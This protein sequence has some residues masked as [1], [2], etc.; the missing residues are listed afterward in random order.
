VASTL[1]FVSTTDS[2]HPGR[3]KVDGNVAKAVVF[4]D[5]CYLGR[6]N[7]VYDAPREILKAIPG[8]TLKETVKSRNK[9][10]C[11]GA[12][13]GRMWIEEDPTQRVNSLRVDQLLTTKPDVIASACPYCMTMLSDGMKEKQLEDSV[14]TR[15]VLEILADAVA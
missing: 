8:L 5:S 14:Q 3:V 10:M 15:D 1:V 7:E 6:Y 13:G 11:C 4:H 2:G 12:G 9:G